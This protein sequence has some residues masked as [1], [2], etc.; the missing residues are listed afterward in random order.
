MIRTLTSPRPF[1][2]AAV[3]AFPIGVRAAARE[4]ARELSMCVDDAHRKQSTQLELRGNRVYIPQRLHF[5]KNAM[6]LSGLTGL[7][8]PARCLITRSTDGFLR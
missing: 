6:P 4:A 2:D 3:A 5:I 1:S 8:L 7:S